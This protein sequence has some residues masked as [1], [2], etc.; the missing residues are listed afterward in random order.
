[1]PPQ[2]GDL[3]FSGVMLSCFL[4]A[5][6]VILTAERSLHFQLRRN[7]LGF[8]DP[9]QIVDD[10]IGRLKMADFVTVPFACT[11]IAADPREPFN[12]RLNGFPYFQAG[13]QAVDKNNGY[14]GWHAGAM[15][16]QLAITDPNQSTAGDVIRPIKCECSQK[17]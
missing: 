13:S 4:H 7:T 15:D 5:F 16:E 11:I 17:S 12:I 8:K 6:S 14:L 9:A 2:D 1:M 3:L 10:F